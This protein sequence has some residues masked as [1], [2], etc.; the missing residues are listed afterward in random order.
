LKC[1]A[2]SEFEILS[3]YSTKDGKELNIDIKECVGSHRPGCK[4]NF[5]SDSPSYDHTCKA[6]I[7][8]LN[9]GKE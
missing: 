5:A 2:D 6:C 9:R 7:K 3:F 4:R 1:A 8:I